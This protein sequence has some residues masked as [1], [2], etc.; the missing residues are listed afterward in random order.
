[1]SNKVEPQ[2]HQGWRLAEGGKV[3]RWRRKVFSNGDIYEGEMNNGKFEGKGTLK[4]RT[5]IYRGTFSKGLF[6]GN[7]EIRW[8]ENEENQ[9]DKENHYFKGS[10]EMGKRHGDG[11]YTDAFGNQFKG[12]W[13]KDK[14]I[15]GTL[16]KK[17]GDKLFGSKWKNSKLNCEDSIITYANG[18]TYDGP[19]RGGKFHG[20]LG[21]YEYSH[22][23]GYYSGQYA[24]GQKCGFAISHY[25]DSSKFRG[26][27]LNGCIHG[28]GSMEYSNGTVYTG[29]WE[30]GKFHG[31]GEIKFSPDHHHLQSYKGEFLK[32]FMYGK[33]KVSYKDRGFYDGDF[34]AMIQPPNNR[35]S[36][37]NPNNK[38]NG[39]GIRVWSTGNSFE[40][41]WE[42]DKMVEGTYVSIVHCS[43]YVGSFKNDK[44]DGFGAEDWR[45]KDG[46]PFRDSS[47]GWKHL[48]HEVPSY[49]GQYKEGYFHGKGEFISPDG[50]SY[51]GGFQKGKF[52]GEGTRIYLANHE[53]GDPS[54]MN[55]GKHGSLYRPFKYVGNWRHGIRHGKGTLF[56]LDG[57]KKEGLFQNGHLEGD[58]VE[59]FPCKKDGVDVFSRHVTY[60]NGKRV[61][62]QR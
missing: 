18:D 27:F 46:K 56:Y 48:G 51:K 13:E 38:R 60:C 32:G 36:Y 29:D 12:K 5:S 17:N 25:L 23:R 42:D 22:G 16:E 62:M 58:V 61:E 49:K 45:S 50:R 10:F 35:K 55:I 54:K 34:L 26:E 57:S 39:Q 37:P 21:R 20:R 59:S 11:E 4:S 31:S 8:M 14:F 40:G 24:N 33:G 3:Y 47:L 9:N 43:K 52:H 44:K 7:G 28:N 15:F 2:Y 53:V 6:H 41:T 30:E 1:M 19:T